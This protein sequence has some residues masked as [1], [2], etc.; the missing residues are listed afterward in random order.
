[1]LQFKSGVFLGFVTD[2]GGRTS[3]TAIV[4]RSMDIPAVVGAREASRL[5]REDDWLIIDGES[6][7]VIVDPPP[8]VIEEYRAIQHERDL[9]RAGLARLR[10]LPAVTLDGEHVELLA[11]IELPGDAAAALQAGAV[12]VGLFRSEFLFMNRAGDLPGEDEQ[13]EAYR[14][15]VRRCAACR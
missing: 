2:V 15:A 5:I 12:G 7:T 11:N 6:G 10:H 3:H 1:M 14:T 8:A 4:A 13:F 9:R